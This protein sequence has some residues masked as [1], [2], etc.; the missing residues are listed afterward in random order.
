MGSLGVYNLLQTTMNLNYSPQPPL[1][2]SGDCNWILLGKKFEF[3]RGSPEMQEFNSKRN[4]DLLQLDADFFD[5]PFLDK[6]F[7]CFEDE[8]DR[9]MMQSLEFKQDDR[10]S[11]FHFNSHPDNSNYLT[12]ANSPCHTPLR[13]L[14]ESRLEENG[15]SILPR[16]FHNESHPAKIRDHSVKIG[17]KRRRRTR[18]A[19]KACGC[20]N[21]KCLR[22]HCR[23][24]KELGYCSPTCGCTDCLNTPDFE[25]ARSFVIK[26]TQEIN[27]NAFKSKGVEVEFKQGKVIN[28]HGC[29]CKTGCR[30]KYC[31]CSKLGAGC[32]PMCRCV[33]CKNEKIDLQKD[34]VT[35]LYAQNKRKKDKIVINTTCDSS[36]IYGPTRK[37][38]SELET[39][40]ESVSEVQFSAK[41]S[42]N[43]NIAYEN[44]KRIK[45]EAISVRTDVPN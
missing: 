5:S 9:Q 13:S 6:S 24:F 36:F 35:K 43:F 30:K 44:Y 34:E 19:R 2:H 38:R 17:F 23:C 14:R 27:K 33:N 10:D 25:E 21:S 11:I 29:N 18:K 7:V 3:S 1:S 16:D 40:S 15:L 37:G 22:L 42:R 31:E 45:L 8:A 12:I 39:Q 20:K 4:S 28:S 32:S 26:K 41:Q